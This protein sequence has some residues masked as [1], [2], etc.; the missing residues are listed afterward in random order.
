MSVTGTGINSILQ[1]MT[2]SLGQSVQGMQSGAS[3]DAPLSSA[4]NVACEEQANSG[5]VTR[6]APSQDPARP[7]G[8]TGYPPT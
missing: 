1:V 7:G 3:L 8:D 6:G 4:W 2:R 5:P